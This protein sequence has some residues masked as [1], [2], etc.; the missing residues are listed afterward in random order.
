VT[1]AKQAEEAR[2]ESEDRF[3]LVAN[4]APVMIWMAKPDKLCNYF[5]QP[6]LTFTGRTLESELGNGWAEGVHP[7][8]L[9]R[10]LDTYT[11]SF[12]QRKTFTMQYRLRRNDG[13]YRWVLDIGVPRFNA[14]GSFAGYIGSAI[15]VTERKLAEE[16]LSSVS[17]KLIEA[18]EHERAW[19]ARELHDDINQR[20]AMV[21]IDLD[22]LKQMVREVQLLEGIQKIQSGLVEI[23]KEVQGI[24]HR[25]HSSKLEYLGLVIACRSFCRELESRHRVQIDFRAENI[26]SLVP[27]D[28]ALA[29]FRILQESLTNALKHSGVQHFEAEL[30]G[31]SHDIHLLVRDSGKG[32]DVDA[33]MN[34]QGLGLISIR[35]RV[36]LLHGTLSISSRPA[37]GTEIKICVPF[38]GTNVAAKLSSGAA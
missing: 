13:E 18:Q 37:Q 30:S 8:D 1:E 29:L 6:W 31:T 21:A 3:R 4:T 25:L 32:F 5:N 28:V 16:A 33:A 34:G 20:I 11:Q 7:D 12:D 23:S 22:E 14:D 15:D 27:H 24:S 19:I 10:C 36:S 9:G 35:E 38:S 26:P 17:R 2:R